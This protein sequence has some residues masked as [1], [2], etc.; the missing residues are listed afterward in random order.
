[1]LILVGLLAI[2]MG[3]V[4]LAFPDVTRSLDRFRNDIDGVQTKQGYW[5]ELNRK[6]GGVMLIIVG[7]VAL[8]V[9]GSR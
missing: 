2:V 4:M 9:S 6:F 7:I 5:Y 3:I 1:M 8:F